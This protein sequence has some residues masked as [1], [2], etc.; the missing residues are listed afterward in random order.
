MR[1]RHP[2]DRAHDGIDTVERLV[3]KERDRQ[4]RLNHVLAGSTNRDGGMLLR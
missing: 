2:P 1:D 4:Y 3:G